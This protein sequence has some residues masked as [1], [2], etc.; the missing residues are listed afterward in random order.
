MTDDLT[1]T[2]S[3]PSPTI[4]KTMYN[5]PENK[6][7]LKTHKAS[8]PHLFTKLGTL[9]LSNEFHPPSETIKRLYVK[10]A[11][12]QKAKDSSIESGTIKFLFRYKEKPEK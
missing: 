11:N 4:N 3:A 2:V 7:F 1:S 5:K 9:K 10:P 6:R 8:A 12:K